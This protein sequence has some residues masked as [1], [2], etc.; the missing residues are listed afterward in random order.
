M[1][2][3]QD[4]TTDVTAANPDLTICD[5][6]PITRPE[7]IQSFGFLLAL[8]KIGRSCDARKT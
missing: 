7:R 3:P 4:P 8:S 6:E 2:G 5:R 1:T